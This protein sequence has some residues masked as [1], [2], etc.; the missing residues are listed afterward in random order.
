MRAMAVCDMV[1]LPYLE[2][3]QSSSGPI[4]IALE[5]G[6]RVLASRTLAFLQFARYHP[7]QIEFFDIGNYAELADLIRFAAP[8]PGAARRLSFNTKTNTALYLTANQRTAAGTG[9]PKATAA[10][11]SRRMSHDPPASPDG[12]AAISLAVSAC[13]N[14]PGSGPRT[15]DI[16]KATHDYTLVSLTPGAPGRS[17]PSSPISVSRARQTAG[18]PARRVDRSGRPAQ[19]SDLGTQPRTAPR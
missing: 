17:M 3:G 18:R 2:V 16:E 12:S 8:A 10:A 7:D 1:V 19:R 11:R 15:G 4:A 14:V 13:S 5:M 9:T 6:C